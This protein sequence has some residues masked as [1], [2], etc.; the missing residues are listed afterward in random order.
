MDPQTSEVST[1]DEEHVKDPMG[2]V[3]RRAWR[4]IIG[5]ASEYAEPLRRCHGRCVGFRGQGQAWEA[6]RTAVDTHEVML[7]IKEGC[8]YCA[9]AE[10]LLR[11]RNVVFATANGTDAETKVELRRVLRLPLVTFPVIFVQGIHLGGADQLTEALQSGLFDQVAASPRKPFPEGVFEIPDPIRLL[12]GPRGQPWYHFQFHCYANYVRAISAVHVAI[13]AIALATSESDQFV[14]LGLGWLL[15][16][17]MTMFT[18]LGPTPFAPLSTCVTLAIWPFRGPAVTSL[19]Y[20]AVIGVA[21]VAS[22]TQLLTRGDLQSTAGRAT[23]GSLLTNSLLL[24]FL[25]F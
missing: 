14:G 11:E 20:K 21:Y 23:L 15:V 3:V 19:P 2:N 17:D 24:T 16:V 6:V 7:F 1:A 25:R 4:D 13:F 9:R 5:Y 8:G 10:G 22:L 18:L 12:V